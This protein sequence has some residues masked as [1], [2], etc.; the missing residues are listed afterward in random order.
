LVD[1]SASRALGFDDELRALER[2]VRT[3]VET[4]GAKTPIAVACFDQSVD[5]SFEGE[6][7]GFGAPE[8]QRIREREALGASNLE[9]ALGWARDRAKARAEGAGQAGRTGA[10]VIVLTDGVATAGATQPS[11]IGAAVTR[12]RDA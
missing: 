7:G 3:I 6:A 10:R 5:P 12:L 8:I 4:S 2:V 9:V 1:T 11:E